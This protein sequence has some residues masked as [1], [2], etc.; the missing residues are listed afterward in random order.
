[1]LRGIRSGVGTDV[2]MCSGETSSAWGEVVM[3]FEEWPNSYFKA[4]KASTKDGQAIVAQ[5]GEIDRAICFS[6]AI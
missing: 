4:S 1:L 6:P 5:I 3:L 2:M